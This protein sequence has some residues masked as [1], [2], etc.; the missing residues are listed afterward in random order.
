MRNTM[1]SPLI[2]N[3]QQYNINLAKIG[4]KHVIRRHGE[5]YS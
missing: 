3:E 5:L 1:K 2:K 4:Q